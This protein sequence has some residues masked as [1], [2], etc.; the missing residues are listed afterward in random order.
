MLFYLGD[1]L[2]LIEIIFLYYLFRCWLVLQNKM[3]F[4]IFRILPH[5]GCEVKF[6]THFVSWISRRFQNNSA[7]CQDLFESNDCF[8]ASGAFSR[9]SAS[10]SS[11]ERPS[12]RIS[13]NS[14]KLPSSNTLRHSPERCILIEIPETFVENSS[15]T[16]PRRFQCDRKLEKRL[17]PR[18][19]RLK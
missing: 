17:V 11:T 6:L 18:K 9:C 4:Y 8:T 3:F 15:E 1:V 14:W 16:V 12:E 19:P 2:Y 10:H 13:K 7:A 5:T